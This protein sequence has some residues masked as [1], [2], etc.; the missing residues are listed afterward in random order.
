MN[1]DNDNMLK[2]RIVFLFKK[3][4]YHIDYNNIRVKRLHSNVMQYRPKQPMV[5]EIALSAG[6]ASDCCI[7]K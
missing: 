5:D 2:K 1:A 6:L 3:Y 4:N 7:F